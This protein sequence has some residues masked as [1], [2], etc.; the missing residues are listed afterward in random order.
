MTFGALGQPTASTARHQAAMVIVGS[1][2]PTAHLGVF[3]DGDAIFLGCINIDIVD[4]IA[5]MA[6]SFI[7]GP[8]LLDKRPRRSCRHVRPPAHRPSACGDRSGLGGG[9]RR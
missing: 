7:C 1:V 4:A 3:G 5:E 8:A 6:I 2:L 9:L